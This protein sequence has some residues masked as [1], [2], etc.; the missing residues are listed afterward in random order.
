MAREKGQ[1][2][3]LADYQVPGCLL[4]VAGIAAMSQPRTSL[5]NA[6]SGIDLALVVYSSPNSW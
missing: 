5:F 1:S 6:I 4:V 3:L 2:S